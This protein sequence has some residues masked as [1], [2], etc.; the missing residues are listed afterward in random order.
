MHLVETPGGWEQVYDITVCGWCFGPLT[1]PHARPV[2]HPCQPHRG[3][4]ELICKADG[5]GASTWDTFCDRPMVHS[6]LSGHEHSDP[7]S[8]VQFGPTASYGD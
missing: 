2:P 7:W 8:G 5:C 1:V 4:W 6:P 3:H